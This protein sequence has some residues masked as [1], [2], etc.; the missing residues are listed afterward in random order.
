MHVIHRFFNRIG[1]ARQLPNG[2]MSE[3]KSCVLQSRISCHLWCALP[4]PTLFNLRFFQH[5]LLRI[6]LHLRFLQHL[7]DMIFMWSALVWALTQAGARWAW[8]KGRGTR[9]GLLK[10]SEVHWSLASI[11]LL[12]SIGVWP[13]L[14]A[15]DCRAKITESVGAVHPCAA[16]WRP[17][18]LNFASSLI[19]GCHCAG[20][21]RRPSPSE[22][23]ERKGN[24]DAKKQHRGATDGRFLCIGAAFPKKGAGSEPRYV[25]GTFVSA[26][27][28]P[29]RLRWCWM[30]PARGPREEQRFVSSFGWL[31][32][33]WACT[34]PVIGK[35]IW[36]GKRSNNIW[37]TWKHW[38]GETQFSNGFVSKRLVKTS[39]EHS[40]AVLVKP[41][42]SCQGSRFPACRS[43][44]LQRCPGRIFSYSESVPTWTNRTC[45][46]DLCGTD[47]DSNSVATGCESVASRDW[48]WL[49]GRFM[50]T[51]SVWKFR[52]LP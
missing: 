30:F 24:A 31:L 45:P 43:R 35:L 38:A 4:S 27:S 8:S 50:V 47:V 19:G 18:C 2:R 44:S 23:K 12:K 49:H 40:R 33:L 34:E 37:E 7:H 28:T 51:S 1:K 14:T 52:A 13:R 5:L 10:T 15:V 36:F 26:A 29:T 48:W 22:K 6:T 41:E 16:F 3:K 21:A 25:F 39:S 17:C 42:R 9:G 11:R 32:G 20:T 46:H